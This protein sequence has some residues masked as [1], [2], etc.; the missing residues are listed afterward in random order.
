MGGMGGGMGGRFQGRI[1][2]FNSKQGF[3]FIEC[4][5][6]HARFGRDVFLHKAQIGD[7]KVGAEVFFSV[8]ANKQG[9]PQAR[10]LVTLDGQAPGPAPP[11]VA[12]GGGMESGGG[13]GGGKGGG[14]RGGGGGK[15][16]RGGRGKGGGQDPGM[17]GMP[18]A[19]PAGGPGGF[20]DGGFSGPGPGG[21]LPQGPVDAPQQ[22]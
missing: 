13:G 19:F 3:G 6:A 1:K 9:M 14:G 21:C 22:L 10:D 20:P 17:M 2:S 4:P 11:T 16:G 5:E 7:L 8:E 18:G 12:N 15:G